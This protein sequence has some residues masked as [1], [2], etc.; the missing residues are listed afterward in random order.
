MYD[1]IVIGLGVMGSAAL[2]E[3]ALRGWRVLGID[4]FTP[5]HTFGSSHGHSRL[6][7]HA[8]FEHPNYVP[9]LDNAYARWRELE[10]ECGHSLM[11]LCGLMVASEASDDV[12]TG[13]LRSASEH[14]LQIDQLSIEDARKTYPQFRFEDDSAV[15]FDP[16]GGF[17]RAEACVAALQESALR[18]GAQ[19]NSDER[20][21]EVQNDGQG[22]R[23]D[24]ELA[25]YGAGAAVICGGP[26]SAE[27]LGHIGIE[28]EVKRKVLSWWDAPGRACDVQAGT[29]AF[30][31][32]ASM[33]EGEPRFFYGVPQFDG[34]GVKVAEHT[35]GMRVDRMDTVDRTTNS[36]PEPELEAIGEFVR[37]YLPGLAAAPRLTEVCLYTNSPDGHFIVDRDPARANVCFAAGFSGH[38][39][40]F[41]PV[42]G[43]AL[44]DL[45]AA[46]E[47]SLPMAFLRAD[48]FRQAVK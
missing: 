1:A 6:I 11:T 45:C 48:R 34:E 43:A 41:A 4:R 9:L 17:L 32:A 10:S 14:N 28:L 16:V 25:S 13:T 15:L 12:I 3:L 22:I 36:G 20:V 38:G 23:V 30:G 31:F 33:G 7:R 21:L 35:G 29:P 40:K 2:R 19:I 39:F 5:G 8:Y 44:A 24:T 47:T 26:W 42:I 27:L 37:R 18:A 46:G